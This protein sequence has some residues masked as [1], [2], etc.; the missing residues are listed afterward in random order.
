MRRQTL[1]TYLRERYSQKRDR[2][3]PYCGAH[4]DPQERCDC[5]ESRELGRL[6]GMGR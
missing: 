6:L 3:C 5:V 4:L 1:E 2:I